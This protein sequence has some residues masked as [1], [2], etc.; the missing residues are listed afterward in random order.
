MH[1]CVPVHGKSC[2]LSTHARTHARTHADTDA[3]RHARTRTRT[4]ARAHTCTYVRECATYG[5]ELL[6]EQQAMCTA[7]ALLE[8]I[9]IDKQ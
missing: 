9:A 5:T 3:R 8:E 2:A 7:E 1:V 6:E 4:H